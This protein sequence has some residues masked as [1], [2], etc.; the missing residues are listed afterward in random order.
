MWLLFLASAWAAAALSCARVCRAA[1]AAAHP[2]PAAHARLTAELTLYETAYL[3]GGPGRVADVALV[4]MAR[5]QQLLL[6]HT[7]W[8][9]VV[10]PI[11]RDAV[12]RAVLAAIGPEGQRRI[13]AI[14]GTLAAGGAVRALAEG[15][16]AAGLALPA[17]GR[18]GVGAAVRQVRTAVLL[19]LLTAGAA[20]WMAPAGTRSG[21]MLAW[22]ALPLVATAGT[23]AMAR[24]EVH[25]YPDWATAA[26]E[27]LLRQHGR[28][29]SPALTALA[30]QGRVALT[31]P[32]LRAALHSSGA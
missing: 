4:S 20:V 14:R 3:A 5:E 23:W 12:E 30:L 19:V 1:L 18:P 11:G 25:P 6:A 17:H 2:A 27:R 22:F 24:W 29:G 8:A 26:G 10:D 15:L 28:E 9:S 21:P 16:V 13:T 31:D 7:G 32:A